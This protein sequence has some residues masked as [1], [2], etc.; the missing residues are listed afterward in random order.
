MELQQLELR[1]N[2]WKRTTCHASYLMPTMLVIPPSNPASRGIFWNGPNQ[3][4]KIRDANPAV[5]LIIIVTTIRFGSES[6]DAASRSKGN[7]STANSSQLSWAGGSWYPLSWC[8]NGWIRLNGSVGLVSVRVSLNSPWEDALEW[9]SVG[10]GWASEGKH[11]RKSLRWPGIE[12]DCV[13]VWVGDCDKL[14]VILIGVLM[15]SWTVYD[16]LH[17]LCKLERLSVNKSCEK[18]GVFIDIQTQ[19]SLNS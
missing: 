7:W 6:I 12:R 9:V 15:S 11:E 13:Y 5:M 3:L 2:A 17:K 14:L 19:Y 4:V 8:L 1:E 10:W 16:Q 18:R